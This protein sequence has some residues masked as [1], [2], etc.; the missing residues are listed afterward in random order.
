MSVD[1][2]FEQYRLIVEETARIRDARH[3][4]SN[5]FL[6]VNAI[7]VGA[8]AVILQQI[9]QIVGAQPV[10]GYILFFPVLLVIG[11]L[12]LCVF[13]L[14][15]LR[16]YS[17]LLEFRFEYLRKCESEYKDRL[18]PFFV[19]QTAYLRQNRVP[20]FTSVEGRIPLVFIVIYICILVGMIVF[21][22]GLFNG[23]QLLLQ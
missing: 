23:L 12:V 7:F 5:L 3:N 6:S 10:S 17:S 19:D 15:I 8:A 20:G 14:K 13:W 22:A 18:I 1:N 2:P 11:G 21:A 16:N 4:I 9:A